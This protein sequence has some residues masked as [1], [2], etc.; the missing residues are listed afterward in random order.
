MLGDDAADGDDLPVVAGLGEIGDGGVGAG[1]DDV[2]D[3]EQRMVA[4]VEPEHLPLVGEQQLLVPLAARDGGL[5]RGIGV[6]AGLGIVDAEPA[7][8]RELAGGLGALDLAGR[9]R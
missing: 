2:L 3:A 9:R 4:D 6:G 1:G 5:Q 8:Q 7:E